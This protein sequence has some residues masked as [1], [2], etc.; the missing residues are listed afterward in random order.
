MDYYCR[1]ERKNCCA[2]EREP[3]RIIIYGIQVVVFFSRSLLSLLKKE[4]RAHHHDEG[5]RDRPLGYLGITH[6]TTPRFSARCLKLWID[7]ELIKLSDS[8]FIRGA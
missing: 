7:R 8:V 6:A 1:A 2:L 3:G 4:T 5:R